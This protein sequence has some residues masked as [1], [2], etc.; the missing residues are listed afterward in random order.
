MWFMSMYLILVLTAV[1]KYIN[2][3]PVIVTNAA[4]YFSIKVTEIKYL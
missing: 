4:A 2:A 3:K 1:M